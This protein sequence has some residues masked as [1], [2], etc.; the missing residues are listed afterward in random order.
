MSDLK[1]E[2]LGDIYSVTSLAV[3]GVAETPFYRIVKGASSSVENVSVLPLPEMGREMENRQYDVVV[4]LGCDF[5]NFV[6]Q[7][8]QQF[9]SNPPLLKAWTSIRKRGLYLCDSV[10]DIWFDFANQNSSLFDCIYPGD[11]PVDS[12][13]KERGLKKAVSI[14]G[15]PAGRYSQKYIDLLSSAEPGIDS[16]ISFCGGLS[17]YPE[18]KMFLDVA[19]K[20]G[21]PVSQWPKE[22]FKTW[23]EQHREYSYEDY[24]DALYRCFYSLNFPRATINAG[25]A[26]FHLKGR[27]YESLITGCT[28]VEELNPVLELIPF[29]FPV[30]NYRSV[31]HLVEL[32][33]REDLV[34]NY[35]RLLNL[36][37]EIIT[38]GM[39]LLNEK[40]FFGLFF[41]S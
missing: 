8:Q 21:L 29:N 18:R 20:S 1:T 11:L 32:I 27:Y 13:S 2:F 31:E 7:L 28:N 16:I 41:K 24:L 12:I 15:F 36:K 10:K 3:F 38:N 33:D 19:I 17:I 14:I 40:R 35:E 26:A 9:N 5:K 22:P 39:N 6:S 34:G 25:K 4:L 37:R 23:Q 30:I